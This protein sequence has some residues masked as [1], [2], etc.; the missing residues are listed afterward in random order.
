MNERIGKEPR[1]RKRWEKRRTEEEKRVLGWE[2]KIDQ[3]K[4]GREE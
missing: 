1:K 4:R 2:E 3:K